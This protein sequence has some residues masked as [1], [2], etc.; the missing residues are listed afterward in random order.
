MRSKLFVPGIRPDLFAKACAGQADAVSF[1]LEDAVPP[2]RKADA[3]RAV[4][5]FLAAHPVAERGKR[6][7]VRVNPAETPPFEADLAA[8]LPLAV[9]LVNLPR[10]ESAQEVFAAVATME[11]LERELELVPNTRLLL[12]IE[13]PRGLRCAAG[14]ATAHPRIAGLQ[15]GLGDLFEP[16]GI[17][18]DMST[19]VHA[20]MFQL[21]MAAAEAG[22]FA[23]DG[24]HPDYTDSEAFEREAAMSRAL[25]FVGKSCI[26]PQQVAWANRMFATTGQELAWA[27][28][29][30]AA[31]Q[32]AEAAGTT[33]FT[34]DGRMVDPPYLRRAQRLLADGGPES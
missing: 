9:D 11:R 10:V 31:A 13:T 5:A 34:V 6:I 24:A 3:R 25:G 26:H 4:A 12:N 22:V 20:A 27:R 1:D 28:R 17:R 33:V 8:I 30:V 2:A 19:H 15:L 23:C 32:V 16:F 14:I 18:R 7:V 21:A 29:V